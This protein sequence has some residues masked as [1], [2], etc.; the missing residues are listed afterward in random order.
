MPTTS[1][2]SRM[3]MSKSDKIYVAGHRGLAGSAILRRLKA[4]GYANLV[5]R[6]HVELDLVNQLAVERFF[7]NEQPDHVFL[8]AA[9]VGGI[10]ANHS[11]PA[12]FIFQNL[13][14][15]NNVIY[16]AWRSGVKRLLFLGSS[17]IYPRACP[18]P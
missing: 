17:C 14:I 11:Y 3:F 13:A 18:Q 9:R 4:G 2:N 12:D 16:S 10:Q 7:E 15:Q 5:I 8:A 1:T 6:D